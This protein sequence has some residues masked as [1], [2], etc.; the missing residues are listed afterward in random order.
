M[1]Q[2]VHADDIRIRAAGAGDLPWI[3]ATVARHFGSVDVVSRGR[4]HSPRDLDGL[5][6]ELG[7]VPAGCLLYRAEDSSIEIVVLVSE[8]PRRGIASRLVATLRRQA[9]SEGSRRLWLVTTNDNLDAIAFYRAN[10]WRQVA[11]YKGAVEKSRRLKPEIPAV[12]PSGLPIE[13]EIE[14]SLDLDRSI[15]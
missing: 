7:G 14:F 3:E 8:K 2:T 12:G 15:D 13:D 10:G 9:M 1:R 6:A 11:I 4:R 5:I